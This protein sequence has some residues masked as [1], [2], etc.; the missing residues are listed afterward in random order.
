MSPAVASHLFSLSL[1]SRGSASVFMMKATHTRNLDHSTLLLRA[2]PATFRRIIIIQGEVG[3]ILAV[4]TDVAREYLPEVAISNPARISRATPR[5]M[6]PYR[7]LV[8]ESNG[9]SRPP[10]VA[11][12]RK[13]QRSQIG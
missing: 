7:S 12:R 5:T 2:I 11:L 10:A 3:S 8:A 13:M 9:A 4:I 6:D 1:K